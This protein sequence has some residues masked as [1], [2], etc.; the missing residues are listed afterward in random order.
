MLELARGEPLGVDVCE[1]LSF[2]A[3]S[4]ATGK[5]TLRPRKSTARVSAILFASWLIFSPCSTTVASF[6]G[7]ASSSS[8]LATISSADSVP[9]MRAR[10]S[11]NR[12]SA[13]TCATNAF[14][15]AT[16]TSGPAC[17]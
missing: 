17:V 11:P 7:T 5:P 1:L 12:Y 9:R 6:S 13:A 4:S 2:S 15:D 16:A 3:P 14:V 10:C 8:V